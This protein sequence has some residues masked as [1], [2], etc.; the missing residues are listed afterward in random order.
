MSCIDEYFDTGDG[1]IIMILYLPT[2]AQ[3]III[4]GMSVIK[5]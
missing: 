4:L 1:E 3:Y 5:L 2:N